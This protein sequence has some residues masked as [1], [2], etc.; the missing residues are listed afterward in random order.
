MQQFV[1]TVGVSAGGTEQFALPVDAG[2]YLV[3]SYA[4]VAEPTGMQ[5]Y[6][7]SYN[8][9]LKQPGTL[10][11]QSI[12][13]KHFYSTIDWNGKIPIPVTSQVVV[14]MYHVP[15]GAIVIF[16]IYTANKDEV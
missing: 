11:W 5:Q 16:S 2:D 10:Q 14:E 8:L 6:C 7:A 1:K 15:I 12:D 3:A 13:C 4:A 9:W